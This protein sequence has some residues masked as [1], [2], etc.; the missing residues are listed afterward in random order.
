MINDEQLQDEAFSFS[1]SDDVRSRIKAGTYCW[2][3]QSLKHRDIRDVIIDSDGLVWW[4]IP[5]YTLLFQMTSPTTT[6]TS[7]RA[8]TPPK[9]G[10]GSI[11]PVLIR[12]ECI[13]L[14]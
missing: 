6:T 13:H 4:N 5:L 2:P 12:T 3:E 10:V 8:T 1:F 14:K 7:R 9:M 11:A